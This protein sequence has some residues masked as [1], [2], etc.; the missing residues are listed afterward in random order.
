MHKKANFQQNRE[1]HAERLKAK[2]L[3][4]KEAEQALKERK[5]VFVENER[6]LVLMS[7]DDF[8]KLS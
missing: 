6:K 8:L 7:T 4:T 1:K 5:A 3:L 2:Q